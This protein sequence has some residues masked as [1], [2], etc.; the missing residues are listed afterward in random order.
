MGR[1]LEDFHI[2]GLSH[3]VPFLAAVMDQARFRSGELSTSYIA[4]EFPDGF[5]GV[6]ADPLPGRRD[7][8]GGGVHAPQAGGAGAAAGDRLAGPLARS[9]LG[10]R[11]GQGQAA[12]EPG[13]AGDVLCVELP[14]EAAHPAAGRRS[15]GGRASRCSAASWTGPPFTVTV[16]PAA[17]GF[18]I[19]H[20]AAKARVLVLTPLSAELHDRLPR[21]RRPTPPSW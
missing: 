15:T 20:R 7:D 16:E 8:R 14:D 4:D 6:D 9:R 2:E 12:G 13:G 10:G 5:D 1:A 3:N 17:E 11:G 18:V 21:R 19:R